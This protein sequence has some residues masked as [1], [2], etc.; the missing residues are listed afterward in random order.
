LGW[1]KKAKKGWP[2][3]PKEGPFGIEGKEPKSFLGLNW[4]WKPPNSWPSL[5]NPLKELA[6]I[7]G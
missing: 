7:K 4:E 1:A 2:K 6:V 3:N 5:R